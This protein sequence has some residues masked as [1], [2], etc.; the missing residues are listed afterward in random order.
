MHNLTNVAAT[1]GRYKHKR[2]RTTIAPRTADPAEPSKGPQ[3]SE[4]LLLKVRMHA[5]APAPYVPFT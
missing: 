5:A 1:G 4:A 3:C 2:R